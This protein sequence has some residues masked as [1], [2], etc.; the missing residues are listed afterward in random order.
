VPDDH[1]KKQKRPTVIV[2][3]GKKYLRMRDET[4]KWVLRPLPTKDK[5]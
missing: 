4:G 1:R 5:E 2:K 3:D